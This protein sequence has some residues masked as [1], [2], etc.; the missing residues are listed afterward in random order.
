MQGSTDHALLSHYLPSY[1]KAPK[2]SW[3]TLEQYIAGHA[4]DG[5]PAVP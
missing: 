1:L 2:A 3:Q 5:E 4:P